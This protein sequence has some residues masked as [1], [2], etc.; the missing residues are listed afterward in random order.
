MRRRTLGAAGKRRIVVAGEASAF[1][2]ALKAVRPDVVTVGQD[3][4]DLERADGLSRR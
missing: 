4:L 3:A 2:A 1:G